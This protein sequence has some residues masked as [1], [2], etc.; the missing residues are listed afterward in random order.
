VCE[1]VDIVTLITVR[2]MNWI[3]H[4]SRKDDI[5]KV[6]H[7]FGSQPEGVRRKGRHRSRWWECVWVDTKKER[8][9]NWRKI[10][11]NNKE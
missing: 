7:M 6:E 8:I 9:T 2:R 3:G 10:F 1:N 11:R 4:V 5:R